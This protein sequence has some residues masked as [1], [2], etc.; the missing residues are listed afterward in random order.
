MP[1]FSLCADINK[2]KSGHGIVWWDT[3]APYVQRLHSALE[4]ELIRKKVEADTLQEFNRPL[5]GL[6]EYVS[7]KSDTAFPPD[8]FNVKENINALL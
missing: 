8:V 6:L 4:E 1:Y 3:Y 7:S 5:D 2:M